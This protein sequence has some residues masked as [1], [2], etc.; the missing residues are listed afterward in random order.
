MIADAIV[1]IP[2]NAPLSN[3]L[4]AIHG[5]RLGHVSRVLSK[6]RRPLADQLKSAGVPI[7]NAPAAIENADRL[8]LVFA[9]AL[10]DRGANLLLR[11]GAE[12]VWTVTRSGI[13]SECEDV[14]LAAKSVNGEHFTVQRTVP[15]AGEQAAS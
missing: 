8:V 10:T 11:Q 7:A 15:Q 3:L 1:A 12:R 2:G 13:W 9:A 14:A 6:N 4:T 5:N